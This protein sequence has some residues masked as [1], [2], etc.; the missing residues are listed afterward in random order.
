MKN[1]RPLNDP[2]V[3]FALYSTANSSPI[4]KDSPY[5]PNSLN[6]DLD[7]ITSNFLNDPLKNEIN[8]NETK[9]SKIFELNFGD[10]I[11]Q[12]TIV[13]FINKYANNKINDK[14]KIVFQEYDWNLFRG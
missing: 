3:H 6:Y 13:G 1:I 4:L 9:L 2:R 11:N 10:F 8:I 7:V 12:I 5:S 14:T